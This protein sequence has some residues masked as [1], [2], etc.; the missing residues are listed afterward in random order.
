MGVEA[1]SLFEP[2]WGVPAFSLFLSCAATDGVQRGPEELR[3]DKSYR[4]ELI[5]FADR[6]SVVVELDKKLE[7]KP[8]VK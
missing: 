7:R 2:Y 3:F 8:Y 1:F 6:A 5:S 4:R